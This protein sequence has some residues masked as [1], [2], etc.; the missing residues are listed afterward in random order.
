[1]PVCVH[2]RGRGHVNNALLSSQDCGGDETPE[3]ATMTMSPVPLSFGASSEVHGKVE[4]G[5][6]GVYGACRV[7]TD[8]A[9]I[10][11]TKREAP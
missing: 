1:M 11:Y 7:F 6:W 3:A 10:A 5:G 2:V 8:Q 4:G 9:G